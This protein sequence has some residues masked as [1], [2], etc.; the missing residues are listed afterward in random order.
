MRCIRESGCSVKCALKIVGIQKVDVRQHERR[1]GCAASSG[2]TFVT[3][4][5]T[6][7]CND[8]EFWS[9][10]LVE[11]ECSKKRVAILHMAFVSPLVHLKTP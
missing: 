6:H 4:C 10:S 11:G 2:L 9:R 3:R 8:G 1:T 7:F 5:K